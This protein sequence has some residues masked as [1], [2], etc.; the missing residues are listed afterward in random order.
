[1]LF[2]AGSAVRYAGDVLR[3]CV[4]ASR[5]WLMAMWASPL[6][7]DT[8]GSSFVL[9]SPLSWAA[10]TLARFVCTPSHDFCAMLT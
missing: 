10:S 6:Q 1:V 9:S 7:A 4:A 5:N 2:A 8:M 3:K